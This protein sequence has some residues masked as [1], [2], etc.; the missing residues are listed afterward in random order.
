MFD[1]RLA[2]LLIVCVVFMVWLG[3]EGFA[4]FK[5][6][7]QQMMAIKFGLGKVT[8]NEFEINKTASDFP[9]ASAFTS[10]SIWQG[11]NM[12]DKQNIYK[13]LMSGSITEA[14]I[15]KMDRDPEQRDRT[16]GAAKWLSY[17][18]D[19]DYSPNSPD[20]IGGSSGSYYKKRTGS[21]LNETSY[22]DSMYFDEDSKGGKQL[23]QCAPDDFACIRNLSYADPNYQPYKPDGSWFDQFGGAAAT[24]APAGADAAQA[25]QAAMR[26]LQVAQQ[27]AQQ[28][29]QTTPQGPVAPA[30]A[31]ASQAPAP[32]ATPTTNV[33]KCLSETLAKLGITSP[34]SSQLQAV[35]MFCTS[36]ATA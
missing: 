22:I 3:I 17:F 15:R 7:P 26:A 33:P 5:K 18:D 1:K 36:P 9:S 25:A 13:D 35:Y 6:T 23:T 10:A 34:S 30:P 12:F 27:Q 31:G 11:M 21:R 8:G 4:I 14:D 19:T 2:L 20:Y 28:Q 24:A 29:A 32:S 16:K